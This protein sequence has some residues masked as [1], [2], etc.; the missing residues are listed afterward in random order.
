MAP[1]DFIKSATFVFI[2]LTTGTLCSY[3]FEFNF[4]RSV[5]NQFPVCELNTLIRLDCMD[6]HAAVCLC[7]SQVKKS[8]II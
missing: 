6:T 4:E 5:S 2:H 7:C 3:Q 8:G 1:L